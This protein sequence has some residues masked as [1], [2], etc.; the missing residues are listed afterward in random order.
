MQN[1]DGE[2]TAV[3]V[4]PLEITDVLDAEILQE[5]NG[6]SNQLSEKFFLL[7]IMTSFCLTIDQIAQ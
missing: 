1:Q 4:L 3:T 2:V 7:R 5:A 6:N